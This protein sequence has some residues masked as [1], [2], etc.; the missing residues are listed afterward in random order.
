M[1]SDGELVGDEAR[2]ALGAALGLHRT[3]DPAKDLEGLE[4]GLEQASAGSL[5]EAL[6]EALHS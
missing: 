6:E 1:E 3:L 2:P 4:P 5:D